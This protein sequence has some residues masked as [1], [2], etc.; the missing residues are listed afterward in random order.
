MKGKNI[1]VMF[2]YNIFS[3]VIGNVDNVLIS[4]STCNVLIQQN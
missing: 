2:F 4:G 3:L 1:D